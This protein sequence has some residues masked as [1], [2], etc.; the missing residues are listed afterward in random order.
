[1][2]D[3]DMGMDLDA[4]RGRWQDANRRADAALQLDIEATR[5]A[6]AARTHQ[7]F[8]RN[9]GWLMAALPL[10]GAALLALLVFFLRHLG[11]WPYALM[12]GALLAV[13]GAQFIVDLRQWY[14]LSQLDLGAPLLQV[15]A[16][17]DTLRTRRL[18]MAKWI[19]LT[20]VLLWWPV[21]LVTLKALTGVDVL[22]KV[23]ASVVWVNFALGLACIPLGMALAAWLSQRYAGSRGFQ[24]FLLEAAGR[25]W[26]QAEDAFAASEHFEAAVANE[27]WTPDADPIELP[28][29]LAGPVRAL[30]RR[31]N[32]GIALYSMLMLA[33]GMFN[34]MHG[35][36][37][38]FL[39][40]GI[41]V[42]LLWLS[43]LVGSIVHRRATMRPAAGVLLSAWR[44]GLDG[45]LAGRLRAARIV[46]VLLPLLLAPALHLLTGLAL[47]WMV[48]AAVLASALLAWRRA[49]SAGF[50]AGFA[51]ALALGALAATRRCL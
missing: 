20:A 36:E 22:P 33:T 27:S 43:Q 47:E 19:A 32:A 31:L 26:Q 25:S 51:D 42:H 44:E 12:S 4:M 46:A 37:A 10:G 13:V 9:S 39:V 15:R 48:A 8:R 34:A 11:D 6:L 24:R 17:L 45:V 3:M 50:A 29:A 21:L 14:A 7:A 5:A 35:G 1:M 38:A 16:V 2:S 18:R 30:R 41:A 49:H 40:A 28:A 23:P